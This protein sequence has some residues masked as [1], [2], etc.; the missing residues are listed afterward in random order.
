[1][2]PVRGDFRSL[3]LLAAL[4]PLGLLMWAAL[5]LA[6]HWSVATAWA[7]AVSA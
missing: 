4:C 1:M 3:L 6:V 7:V 5:F 2:E